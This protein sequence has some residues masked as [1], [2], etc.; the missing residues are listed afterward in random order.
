MISLFFE[1]LILNHW[2]GVL[3]SNDFAV[4]SQRRAAIQQQRA[5]DFNRCRQPNKDPYDTYQI[6]AISN[7]ELV[8]WN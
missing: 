3:D 4:S 2:F 8:V 7:G 5:C 6:G 1:F